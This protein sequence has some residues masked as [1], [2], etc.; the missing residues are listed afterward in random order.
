[1]TDK[2]NRWH[3]TE[4]EWTPVKQRKNQIVEYQETTQNVSSTY[5]EKSKGNLNWGKPRIW[6][7]PRDWCLSC[8]ST[9]NLPFILIPSA[10]WNSPLGREI[11]LSNEFISLSYSSLFTFFG[12]SLVRLCPLYFQIP[13]LKFFL[14]LKQTFRVSVIFSIVRTVM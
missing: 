11:Y 5:M 13:L 14:N 10:H 1:M 8:S 9:W 2:D 7:G 6:K 4:T 12:S 3:R